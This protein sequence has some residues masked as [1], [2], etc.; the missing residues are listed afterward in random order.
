VIRGFGDKVP[1]IAAS[2]FIS[3]AA[4]VVGDVEVGENSS[5]WPGAVLRGDFAPIKIGS[6][7]QVEDNCVIHTGE[8]LTIGEI[9]RASCRERV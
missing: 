7:T 2:A 4:Y 9:G 5:V 1:R 8:P 3:E 6:N